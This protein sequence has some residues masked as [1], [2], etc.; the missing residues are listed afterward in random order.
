MC[1][2]LS[3]KLQVKSWTSHPPDA[4]TAPPDPQ[5]FSL[6]LGG[7]L[8]QLLRR[9]HLS[10]DA[11]RN[12]WWAARK[13]SRW[14]ISVTVSRWWRPCPWRPSQGDHPADRG[15]HTRASWATGTHHDAIG[16]TAEDPVRP[17][18]L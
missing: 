7:P 10:D 16:G 15:R 17:V 8:F 9:A 5:E 2:L 4:S 3:E 14:P 12:P 13:S 11:L 18:V 6:V 1:F